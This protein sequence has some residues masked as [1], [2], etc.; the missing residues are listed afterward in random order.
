MIENKTDN[1][2]DRLQFLIKFT[3]GQAQHLV[4]SCEYMSPN[5]GYQKAKELFKENFGNEYRISC[6][7]LERLFPG[8]K[9]NLRILNNCRIMPCS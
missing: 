4:K 2:R 1:N 7:Y 9:S 6:A 3:K 8:P 5:R